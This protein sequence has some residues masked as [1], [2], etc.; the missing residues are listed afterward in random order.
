MGL[1][2]AISGGVGVIS[3]AVSGA[4]NAFGG[5]VDSIIHP[6]S[7]QVVQDS[8][9]VQDSITAQDVYTPQ[10][11]DYNTPT[12]DQ[13]T[14]IT[15]DVPQQ[16]TGIIDTI[17]GGAGVIGGAIGSGIEKLDYQY[18]GGASAFT[19]YQSPDAINQINKLE[20]SKSVSEVQKTDSDAY[21][22]Q[23]ADYNMPTNI[24]TP[25]KS[26][27]SGGF[28][29]S[30]VK[31]LSGAFT[32]NDSIG[33][34]STPSYA[35][36]SAALYTPPG[37]AKVTDT[38]TAKVTGSKNSYLSSEDELP[39]LG[40]IDYTP[41][42]ELGD[43]K[44]RTLEDSGMS[45]A[46]ALATQVV[47]AS[48]TGNQRAIDYYK[49]EYAKLKE[50]INVAEP[51]A[52]H[53]DA[54]KS[55]IPTRTNP[56]EHIADLDA[57]YVIT[58]GSIGGVSSPSGESWRTSSNVNTILGESNLLTKAMRS[59]DTGD[60]GDVGSS[61]TSFDG[62]MK[63]SLYDQQAIGAAA[64][65]SAGWDINPAIMNKWYAKDSTG[66]VNPEIINPD[67]MRNV[68]YN[69][70]YNAVNQPTNI[71]DLDV[72][73]I[74]T[75][76]IANAKAIFN[77][78]K[79]DTIN[80]DTSKMVNDN[81]LISDLNAVGGSLVSDLN[82][83]GGSALISDLNSAG[84]FAD[85]TNNQ[86]NGQVTNKVS[87]D[88]N[89]AINRIANYNPIAMR[90]SVKPKSYMQATVPEINSDDAA[91]GNVFQYIPP[92]NTPG[93]ILDNAEHGI[94]T[95][96]KS[97]K[98]SSTVKR[99]PDIIKLAD[100][101]INTSSSKQVIPK[102]FGID[103]SQFGINVAHVPVH[104]KIKSDTKIN[105]K[106]FTMRGIHMPDVG[107]NFTGMP[108]KSKV[109]LLD[110][111]IVNN[112]AKKHQKV[113]TIPDIGININRK[114]A[115]KTNSL[116]KEKV[117]KKDFNVSQNLKNMLDGVSGTLS[118]SLKMIKKNTVR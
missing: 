1:F 17:L 7:T 97:K 114:G 31:G 46:Q 48:A 115:L 96:R 77:N 90:N 80:K 72:G 44:T 22:P 118:G 76:G 70:P 107:M 106:Q 25:E 103:I 78:N 30:L 41:Q 37:T 65:K 67:V 59:G 52:F 29:D 43:S 58:P 85:F 15:A 101:K 6:P 68:G 104:S 79:I 23:N 24:S 18:G 81:A 45:V 111:T 63:L 83:A 105:Q 28:V 11:V 99:K 51:E 73:V 32:T 61:Y 35:A 49:N 117:I 112:I 3:G 98:S 39:F 55:G 33:S 19:P 82:S 5:A 108:V 14:V 53:E 34:G 71:N 87:S 116:K 86:N 102:S 75:R 4:E 66:V 113:Y 93:S 8:I 110:T 88:Q 12:V 16:N 62:G 109:Q 56:F 74:G 57:Q 50:D 64:A 26:V 40:R 94:T 36:L 95:K 21:A 38:G 91:V 69:L 84:L 20:A 27:G 89:A 47:E 54:L 92:V 42:S 100:L 2:E 10:N 9:P 13:P 60:V